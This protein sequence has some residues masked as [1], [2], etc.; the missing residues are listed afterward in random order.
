MLRSGPAPRRDTTHARDR[1]LSDER[2]GEQPAQGTEK[3]I[4]QSG[5]PEQL[6]PTFE[7]YTGQESQEERERIREAKPDILLTNFMMLELLMTRQNALIA[8]SSQTRTGSTSSYS[9]SSIPI[10]DAKAPTSRCL[11][12]VCATGFAP[13]TNRFALAHQQRWQAREA[14]PSARLQSRS[15]ASRLFGTAISRDAVIDESLARATDPALKPANIS[16]SAWR[17]DRCGLPHALDDDALRTHPLAVWIELEIGLADG[18]RLSRHPPITINEAAKRL[19]EQTG[20]DEARCR[21]QLQAAAHSDEP[22]GKRAGRNRRSRFHGLQ[23][24]SVHFR[25]GSRLHDASLPP[26]RTCHAWTVNASIPTIRKRGFTRLSSAATADRSITLSF[27]SRKTGSGGSCHAIS[28]KRRSMMQTRPNKPGYLMPEPESD[29]DYS[30]AGAPEDYPEEWLDSSRDGAIRLRSDRRPYA[31]QA[32]HRRPGRHGGHDRTPR[33]VPTGQI[34]LL[35]RLRRPTGGAGTRNQQVGKP[36]S[37]GPKL[38]DDAPRVKR[39]AMDERQA[40]ALPP[41]RRK[42]LG[43]TDN[44]QDAALQAGH[45]NDFLFVALLRAATLAAV[46]AAGPDGLS[47]DEFGRRLQTAL[48]FT[49]A[50]AIGARNGCSIPRSKASGKWRP[51]ARWLG[52]WLIAPGSISAA[53]GDSP[54]PI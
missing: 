6:R 49:A 48:G 11:C 32:A 38:R 19:A 5:L 50:N 34:S 17:G 54:T 46:R 24:A 12:A 29:D 20:R 13:I 37:R 9:T 52:S 3:F 4:D 53:A 7:R 40:S 39:V 25:R 45:F 16:R 28:T 42:L 33:L 22:A 18:Q 36:V 26:Q 15:V 35:S 30:F 23:A 14:R 31:A 2:V 27:S 51:N 41:V 44:R 8:P 10:A 1:H 43:F 47:E 21:D